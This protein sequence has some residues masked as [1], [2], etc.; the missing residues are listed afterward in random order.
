MHTGAMRR[1]LTRT[2]MSEGEI[3]E[4]KKYRNVVC[5]GRCDRCPV[6][7]SAVCSQCVRYPDIVCSQ[8]PCRALEAKLA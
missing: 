5:D 1:L 4:V 2:G 7:Q 8:C 6:Q 3:K